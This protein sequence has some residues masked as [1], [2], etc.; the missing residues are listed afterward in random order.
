MSQHKT[1]RE[2]IAAALAVRQR[3]YAPYSGFLV[4]C[5]VRAGE[6]LFAGAN[7]ENASYGLTICAE[8]T[9]CANAALGGQRHVDVAVVASESSPPVS[10]CGMCLQTLIEFSTD[11]RQTRI[12]LINP[13][14]ERRDFVLADL[15]PHS[16]NKSDLDK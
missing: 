9:A 8:R 13:M 5:V 10:P 6:E 15:I 11:P 1:D 16:F 7:I 14:G 3:A 12:I 4:G 2:L